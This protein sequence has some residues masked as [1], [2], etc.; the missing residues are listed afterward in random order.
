MIGLPWKVLTPNS[1]THGGGEGKG[2]PA[3]DVNGRSIRQKISRTGI[4]KFFGAAGRIPYRPA[5][6]GFPSWT[7]T[8]QTFID[9]FTLFNTFLLVTLGFKLAGARAKARRLEIAIGDATASLIEYQYA[10]HAP[11]RG[12]ADLYAQGRPDTTRP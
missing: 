8:M 2:T 7:K 5:Q 6:Y 3:T 9:V 1:P 12:Q 4:G 11:D 10:A